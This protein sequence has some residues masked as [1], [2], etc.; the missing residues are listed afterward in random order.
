MSPQAGSGRVLQQSS[1]KNLGFTYVNNFAQVVHVDPMSMLIIV[2]PLYF[3]AG[4]GAYFRS[5][6]QGNTVSDDIPQIRSNV[7]TENMTPFENNGPDNSN[8]PPCRNR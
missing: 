3:I 4:I 2:A 6:S 8:E 1:D 5:F 7:R